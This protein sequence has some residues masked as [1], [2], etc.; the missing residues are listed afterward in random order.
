MKLKDQIIENLKLDKILTRQ[1]PNSKLSAYH[2]QEVSE[3]ISEEE[4]NTKFGFGKQ[5]YST[6]VPVQPNLKASPSVMSHNSL[7]ASLSYPTPMALNQVKGCLKPLTVQAGRKSPDQQDLV[8]I[9]LEAKQP[10]DYLPTT[11]SIDAK[12]CENHNV[13][14]LASEEVLDEQDDMLV[15]KPFRMITANQFSMYS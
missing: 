5:K 15:S 6:I 2:F 3:I 8:V 14:L 1:R 11:E 7:D 10:Y 9:Q 13:R 4:S 12:V